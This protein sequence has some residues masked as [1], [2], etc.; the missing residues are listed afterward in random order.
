MG[1][2]KEYVDK[3][4]GEILG[5]MGNQPTWPAMYD[6]YIELL[7][8]LEKSGRVGTSINQMEEIFEK[9]SQIRARYVHFLKEANI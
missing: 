3:K 1:T 4:S 9:A 7:S 2:L 8:F 5:R 6:R